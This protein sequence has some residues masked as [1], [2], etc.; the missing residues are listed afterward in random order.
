MSCRRTFVTWP[1]FL[2]ATSTLAEPAFDVTLNPT[3]SSVTATL[4]VQGQSGTDTSPIAGS[5]RIRLDSAGTPASIE[6][7]DFAFQ[8]LEPLNISIIF[9]IFTI[10]IGSILVNATDV[11][12]EYATPG[13]IMG[14]VPIVANGFEF[15][16]VPANSDGSAGYTATGTVCTLLQAQ[17]PPADC[18]GTL[19]LAET[20][21]QNASS[22]PGTITISGRTATV[23]GSINISG[24]ID[25]ENPDLGVL[26]ISGTFVGTGQIPFCP[27]DFD[28][29]GSVAVPDIFA[30][31]S[32]W[33]AGLPS[34]DIDGTPGVGVPDI[35]AF[36]ARWF[37][38]C[39]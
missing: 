39:A 20:G 31:L 18:S 28:Q 26:A 2:I 12:V 16:D 4:T 21:T 6:L 25:P 7:H 10:P 19:D 5:M 36:L 27:G 13:V 22:L 15:S 14:P 24:P 30:Y 9:R 34:A 17:T 8:A 3:L 38:S 33:F 23:S 1:I 35:F 11:S 32:A 29:N 37:G